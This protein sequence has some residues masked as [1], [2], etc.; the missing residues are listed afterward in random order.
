MVY[1][2]S[3]LRD[4][5]LKINLFVLFGC[6]FFIPEDIYGS[7]R[8]TPFLYY[9]AMLGGVSINLIVLICIFL[10]IFNF[11]FRDN[12]FVYF[13]IV[14]TIFSIALLITK[15]K[16]MAY[17]I[18]TNMFIRDYKGIICIFFSYTIFLFLIK[19]YGYEKLMD[20]T[21]YLLVISS[22]VW[23]IIQYNYEFWAPGQYS[24]I[25]TFDGGLILLLFIT[26]NHSLVQASNTDKKR[27]YIF[28]AIIMLIL[29]FSHRRLA[30]L[31]VAISLISFLTVLKFRKNLLLVLF[32]SFFLAIVVEQNF[33][34]INHLYNSIQE[35]FS[36][37][38]STSDLMPII[39]EENYSPPN[40]SASN[41]Q[42]FSEIQL[43]LS[44]IKGNF[45]LPNGQYP[46]NT[47]NNSKIE[48]LHNFYLYV[49]VY[50]GIIGF[51]LLIFSSY[52]F[53]K[54]L[55]SFRKQ[56]KFSLVLII[57]SFSFILFGFNFGMNPL[58]T[59]KYALIVGFLLALHKLWV[60]S[61]G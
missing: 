46:I 14:T 19:N 48:F 50:W 29:I 24:Y 61:N 37:G 40:N 52:T 4:S 31:Y 18:D 51:I 56:Q 10:I 13:V 9:K 33:Y 17:N 30:N 7:I 38:S 44:M 35:K 45:F 49:Y 54:R 53:L 22:L 5:F 3:K 20:Y 42:H 16:L 26:L 43:A 28:S 21:T 47:T 39:K 12:S 2:F 23:Q 8:S 36:T 11:D 27:F 57:P 58:I 59:F 55:L 15:I 34:N 41:A 60:N 1:N 6:L 32:L 25:T